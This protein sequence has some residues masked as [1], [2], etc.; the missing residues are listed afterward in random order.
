LTAGGAGEVETALL[1]RDL[2]IILG[3]ALAFVTLFRRLGLGAV[4]GYLLAGV[5]LGPQGIGVVTRPETMLHIAD[6]GI[7]LLLFLVGLELNPNRLWRLKH[8]IFGLGLLQVVVSGLAIA[9]LVYATTGLS[10]AAS[11]AIGLP[12]G[13]SS[14][15]QVLPS[16]RASGE[17]NTRPGERAFSILLLQDLAIVPM[18]VIVAAMSRAPPDPAAPPGW[19]LGLYAVGAIIGLVLAGRFL[20]NPMFR[21]IGRVSERELFVVAGLFTVLAAAAVMEALHLSMALGAF[22]AG[23]MLADSPYR[24]E[25]EADIDPFRSILLGLFFV[26]VGMMLDV[27]TILARPWFVV[28]MAAALVALKAAILFGLAR[29][30]GMSGRRSLKLGL[31]LSQGGEFGFVLFA[32]AQRAVLIEPAAASLF[33]AVV[34]LSMATTPFLMMLNDRIDRRAARREPDHLD[35]PSAAEGG[36]EAILVGYGRF[37]QTVAQMLMARG[38][39]ITIIDSKPSQIELSGTFGMK[40]YYGDGLRLDLLRQAGG[41]SAQ[42][43]LFCMDGP[44]LNPK[45]LEPI[46]EAFPQAAVFVRAFDRRQVIALAGLDVAGVVREVFESAVLMGKGV[47]ER[48]GVPEEDVARIE[49]VFRDRDAERLEEQIRS[50][51]LHGLKERMFRPDAPMGESEGQPG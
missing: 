32:E 48:L 14:T 23:V 18:I 46:L 26:A 34:T 13:L 28:G 12:L 36:A 1:L 3:A 17:I 31:L 15:A 25:L 27:G 45:R 2:V 7:V 42:A 6:L 8:D 24:H 50:G 19:Q 35:G 4:L 44:S 10:A 38:I 30:F 47:L 5:L 40:V 9:L 16:L 37:G 20:I 51:D 49:R 43:I 21:V 39:R 22:I 41:G 33:G 11:L 29:A